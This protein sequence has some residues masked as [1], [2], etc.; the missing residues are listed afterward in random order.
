IS[1]D[2]FAFKAT[3]KLNV[4]RTGTWTFA[5]GSDQYAKL[6]IDGQQVVNDSQG[7]S[8]RWQSGSITL[9]VGEHDLELQYMD[10]WSS[11]GAFLT[12]R[13][14]GDAFEEVIPA[15]AFVSKPKRVRVVR[16]RE[17]GTEYNR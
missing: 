16:W 7:H 5:V 8:Y 10:G 17:I 1:S 11:A 15:S 3:G 13:G 14:P 6:F 4:P 2:Y 12:W 9:D